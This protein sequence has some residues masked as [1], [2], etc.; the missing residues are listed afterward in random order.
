LS[1][2]IRQ[3]LKNSNNSLNPCCSNESSI[4]V[5]SP[6]D[7]IKLYLVTPEPVTG[8]GVNIVKTEIRSGGANP[9]LRSS[10]PYATRKLTSSLIDRHTSLEP[11]L[12]VGELAGS[13]SP[14]RDAHELR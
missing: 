6:E 10:S 9:Y 4:F 11:T 5:L 14:L 8:V 7:S 1:D 13:V 3:I 2:E 12:S